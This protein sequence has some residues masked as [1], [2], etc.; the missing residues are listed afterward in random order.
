MNSQRGASCGRQ[1]HCKFMDISGLNWPSGSLAKT[2]TF[3]NQYF[4]PITDGIWFGP[5]AGHTVY[6]AETI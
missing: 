3:P 1:S 2:S 5:F 6:L 4:P